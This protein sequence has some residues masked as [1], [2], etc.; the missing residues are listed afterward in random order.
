MP[1]ISKTLNSALSLILCCGGHSW[2]AVPAGLESFEVA[3]VKP[4]P[5]NGPALFDMLQEAHPIGFVPMSSNRVE[6]RNVSLLGII[7]MAFSIPRSNV[8]GP[9]W[10]GT[11]RFDITA[12]MPAGARSSSANG[13]LQRL[14][15]ER[16]LLKTHGD[17]QMQSGYALT[18]A[19]GG[20]RLKPFS[21]LA[22][23]L[24]ARQAAKLNDEVRRA[25]NNR[26]EDENAFLSLTGATTATIALALSKYVYAP[27]ADLTGIEGKYD[28][29][30]RWHASK[31]DEALGIP[32][33]SLVDAVKS[34]GLRLER[35]KIPV[36]LLIVDS[37]SRIPVQN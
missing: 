19:P 21:G 22:G 27:V 35:R 34:L 2:A 1:F 37:V 18:V 16:F 29:S 31:P 14:L 17:S 20:A 3:S 15:E 23:D 28:I 30:L 6:I 7:S 12:L 25:E 9:G 33:A 10:M 13:M 4:A 11:Q 26:P 5:S 36:E 32:A 8:S 24:E